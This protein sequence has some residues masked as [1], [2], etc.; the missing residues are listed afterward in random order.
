MS[1]QL[2]IFTILIC[3]IVVSCTDIFNS[4]KNNTYHINGQIQHTDT[5]A[6]LV[7][8]PIQLLA[9][10]QS[11]SN[12]RMDILGQDTTDINGY[13]SFSYTHISK[14]NSKKN[15]HVWMETIQGNKTIAEFPMNRN[16]ID[17]I[18]IYK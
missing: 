6:P 4:D 13:F 7:S 12:S 15:A 1:Y 18:I 17:T 8:L 11:G 2:R 3:S 5:K 10:Y 16:T 9:E 14:I